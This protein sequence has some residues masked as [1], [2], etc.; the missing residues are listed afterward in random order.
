MK[1]Y[2]SLIDQKCIGRKCEFY[3]G[4]FAFTIRLNIL[5]SFSI[6]ILEKIKDK[7]AN[8]D[9]VN[10]FLSKANPEW[11]HLS[12]DIKTI[13]AFL[14]KIYFKK[15]NN[16]SAEIIIR[17]SRMLKRKLYSLSENGAEYVY[18][19][20]EIFD[21]CQRI[22]IFNFSDIDILEDSSIENL[23]KK[24]DKKTIIS[25]LIILNQGLKNN[26]LKKIKPK[27][28]LKSLSSG[29]R[30]DCFANSEKILCEMICME[31]TSR[32]NKK[33]NFDFEKPACKHWDLHLKKLKFQKNN[34][35]FN[36]KICPLY[37]KK[38]IG[39]KCDYF[40]II[41]NQ[42]HLECGV[43]FILQIMYAKK[44]LNISLDSDF[45]KTLVS[46]IMNFPEVYIKY[47]LKKTS[48]K[49][50]V[51]LFKIL[52]KKFQT[53]SQE[54]DKNFLLDFAS[55]FTL[56]ELKNIYSK[57]EPQEKSLF[58]ICFK[59]T[60]SFDEIFYLSF[61]RTEEWL[62]RVAGY[63]V[64]SAGVPERE[65]QLYIEKISGVLSKRASEMF[66]DDLKSLE[67]KIT[68]YQILQARKEIIYEIRNIN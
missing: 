55:F 8:N 18:L 20:R 65:N 13:L 24:F 3:P 17:N 54:K 36:H 27:R 7:K 39:N 25:A 37:G 45:S 66:I 33:F 56:K 16:N 59:S 68:P 67:K 60:L 15:P 52:I 44:N 46:E 29:K 5:E 51:F 6:K 30:I 22:S 40:G 2:C 64:S 53:G 9:A 32:L 48:I 23:I 49:F 14:K 10:L 28:N 34:I 35:N 11:G 63:V 19:P 26:L 42:F 1:K 43:K 41:E 21:L 12:A 62:K 58:F 31:E 4:S 47:L 57:L 50:K 38:C 61:E